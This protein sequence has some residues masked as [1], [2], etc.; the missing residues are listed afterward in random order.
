MKLKLVAVA[1]LATIVYAC[2][3]KQS[4]VAKA[5]EPPKPPAEPMATVM[6]EELIAGQRSYE[7]NCAKCH[8]LFAPKEFSKDQWGP[9]LISMQKKAHLSDAEMVPITNYIYT[10]L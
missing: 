9:I 3:P 8:R 2:A 6:T 1:V 4:T 10:Q 5:P 7:N